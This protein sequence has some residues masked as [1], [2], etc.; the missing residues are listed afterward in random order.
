VIQIQFPSLGQPDLAPA[1]KHV[2]IVH[3]QYTP[4]R[5][6][7]GEWSDLR[8]AVAD[9]AFRTIERQLR[10]FGARVQARTVLTPADLESQFGLREGA[11][12][13]GEL[14]LD[15]L[16]F[17]RP[18]PDV[19]RHEG[20]VAGLFLCGAGAHPGPGIVGASGRMAARALLESLR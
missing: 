11:V 14:A 2:A 15:Q 10:G 19:A 3:V 16:L 1:G 6:R 4:Y 7:A 13:C 20:P 18:T 9:S 12:S 5:L 8:E 17:M